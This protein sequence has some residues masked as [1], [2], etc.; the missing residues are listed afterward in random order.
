MTRDIYFCIT[1]EKKKE[2]MYIEERKINFFFIK[3]KR[4]GFRKIVLFGKKIVFIH[5]YF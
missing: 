2:N 4:R 3:N 1:R 5:N